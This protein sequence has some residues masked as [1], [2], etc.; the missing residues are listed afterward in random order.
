M[1]DGTPVAICLAYENDGRVWE[2]GGAIMPPLYRRRGFGSR[3]VRAALAEI[4]ET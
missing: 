4:D 3:I 2:V 1:V